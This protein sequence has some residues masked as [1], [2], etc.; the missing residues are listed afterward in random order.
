MCYFICRR[1]KLPFVMLHS[2][3]RHYFSTLTVG[4]DA[5]IAPWK[6]DK[7][8]FRCR[9]FV[10]ALLMEVA[11]RSRDRGSFSLMRL[12]S[13]SQLRWQLPHWRSPLSLSPTASRCGS[14]TLRL[15]TSTG[16]SFTTVSTLR[17]PKRALSRVS[18]AFGSM[19]A[20]T[21]TICSFLAHHRRVRCPH[22]A[23]KIPIWIAFG[24]GTLL[25]SLQSSVT[26]KYKYQSTTVFF[27]V[28]AFK[29]KLSS[30]SK[31]SFPD[32]FLKF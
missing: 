11:R 28:P 16:L 19:W 25:P 9:I 3:V 10:A 15:W 7:N 29:L 1:V 14:V 12:Y 8:C 27:S 6:S 21:P 32:I 4:C 31:S 2:S 20:S 18:S 22:R 24:V 26:A 13:L 30:Q 23:L 5:H 17:Y